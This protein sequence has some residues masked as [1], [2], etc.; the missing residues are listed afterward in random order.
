MVCG[1]LS[2]VALTV[3]ALACLLFHVVLENEEFGVPPVELGIAKAKWVECCDDNTAP[4]QACSRG[5]STQEFC[6]K[7]EGPGVFPECQAPEGRAACCSVD[8]AD[9]LACED[10]ISLQR[11]CTQHEN[12]TG[13]GPDECGLSMSSTDFIGGD[14]YSVRGVASATECCKLCRKDEKCGAWSWGGDA[15]SGGDSSHQRCFLKDPQ[16]YKTQSSP[17]MVSGL[18][19][20]DFRKITLKL[21]TGLCLST[22]LSNSFKLQDCVITSNSWQQEFYYIERLQRISS[23]DGHCVEADPSIGG[24]L[25]LRPCDAS[26]SNQR[27]L[28]GGLHGLIRLQSHASPEAL[29]I[30]ASERRRADSEVHMQPCNEK[31]ADQWWSLWNSDYKDKEDLVQA[32]L[33]EERAYAPPTTLLITTTTTVTSPK[34]PSLFCFSVMV[35]WNYEPNLIRW[36]VQHKWSIFSCDDFTVYSDQR[37]SLGDNIW[38]RI[39]AGTDLKAH[40]GG[41]FNT[42]LNT[43][44]F[45]RVWE[46]VVRDGVYDLYDW[47]AKVD[48]DAVFLPDR[49]RTMV[50]GPDLVHGED[51]KGKFINN[52]RFGL[53]G[54]LEVVS[55]KAL[56]TYAKGWETCHNDPP[57]EDVYLMACLT[58][59]GVT[60]VDEFT[61]LS[62]QACKTPDWEACESSHVA[63]HPFKDLIGYKD[64]ESRAE[65]VDLQRLQ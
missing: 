32:M 44:V 6:R 53:H 26:A 21:R 65:E 19:G 57:Q 60:Q 9:C 62:E 3:V 18:P 34:P 33:E 37:M 61:L 36:Q 64:C 49:L 13:C 38:S 47:T 46:Q 63:F 24:S 48:C 52:C 14:L 2:C 20:R 28:A 7:H 30:H 31:S 43:P 42:L 15:G 5:L 11:Y 56:S 17:Y 16:Q 25:L 55:R 39:V 22:W 10:R 41:K 29:C 50:S 54:P 40:L 51:D 4:C 27:W 12:V 59:L 8:L 1:L 35:S 45:Q 23:S 58:Q